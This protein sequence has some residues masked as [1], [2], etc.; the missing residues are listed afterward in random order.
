MSLI[1]AFEVGGS[2]IDASGGA[3]RMEHKLE[4]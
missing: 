2:D 3:E 1:W 4:V